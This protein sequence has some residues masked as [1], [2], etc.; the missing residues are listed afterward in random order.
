MRKKQKKKNSPLEDCK[1]HLEQF[2]TTI[3]ICEDDIMKLDERWQKIEQ[4]GK[5]VV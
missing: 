1:R 4:N 5:Y 3:K 2:L